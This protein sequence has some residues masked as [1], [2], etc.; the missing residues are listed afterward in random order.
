MRKPLLSV[1]IPVYNAGHYLGQCLDSVIRQTLQD[2]EIICIDD[3]SID[4]SPGILQ[5][6][7]SRDNRIQIINQPNS[8]ALTARKKAVQSSKGRYI[9]FLDPDD[10]LTSPDSLQTMTDAIEQ[11]QADILH[12]SSEVIAA[13][14]VDV[15][16]YR[17]KFHHEEARLTGR[18]AIIRYWHQR[19]FWY[20][21][22][23]IYR[24]ECCRQACACI[25]DIRMSIF[26]DIYLMF[27]ISWFAGT[28][29]SHP[30]KPLVSYRLGSGISTKSRLSLTDFQE[31]AN[32][33]EGLSHLEHFI[34]ENREQ[35]RYAG[36]LAE[37]RHRLTENTFSM[38]GKLVQPDVI[39]AIACLMGN[40]DIN[41]L[42]QRYSGV[43]RLRYRLLSLLA[44][45]ETKEK[46]KRKTRLYD[47]L[48][49]LKETVKAAPLPG[50][51]R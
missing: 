1:C 47:N 20:L 18:E 23:S 26:E 9:C 31:L 32:A 30:G 43:R 50:G 3:G 19:D 14:G 24:G 39:P 27:I 10:W 46:Y 6:Y 42:V 40:I 4:H 12:F 15:S 38:L 22:P 17:R 36:I 35:D 28:L 21:W 37:L 49:H 25:K 2:I 11:E 16:G 7:Q 5:A 44:S 51:H 33:F 45:G 29:K 34:Q 48:H 8:G 41:A 13:Q